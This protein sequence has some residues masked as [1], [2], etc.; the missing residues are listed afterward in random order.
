MKKLFGIKRGGLQKKMILIVLAM[1]AALVVVFTVV[2]NYQGSM[3]ERIVNDTGTEQQKAIS[4]TSGETLQKTLMETLVNT[5]AL[6]S[7]LADNDFSEVADNANMLATMAQV[8]LAGS[9]DPEPT[10]YG[11]PDPA[12]EGQPSA[13]VLCEE[14]VDY[15][16]SEYLAAISPLADVMLAMFKNS[17]KI[18]GCY[19]GLADGTDLC[20][21]ARPL[22]KLDENGEPI[23]FPV[24]E[25]PWYKGALEAGEV[26][27]T[28]IEEDAFSGKLMVTCSAPVI[29]NGETLGVVGIDIVMESMDD[30]M[31]LSAENGGSAF[32]VNEKGRVI[33]ST[34]TEGI[35]AVKSPSESRDLRQLGNKDLANFVDHA[36]K[37]NTA[38]K[39]ITI[40]GKQYY[41]SGSPMKTIGWTVISIIEKELTE[42][43]EKA[44][45]AEFDK[46]SKEAQ[47]AIR[48]GTANVNRSGWVVIAAIL[49]ISVWL[50]FYSVRKIT[51]P[52]NEMTENVI[53]SG[54]SGKQFELRDSYKTNDEIEILARA[55][56]DLSQKTRQYIQDIQEITKEKER[57]NTELTMASRI[58]SGSLP[59][60]FPAFPDRTEF[61]IYASMTPAKEVGGDFYDF[62][63]IDEDHLCMLIAD[64]SGK[65]IPGALFMMVS[66]A[67]LKN[68]AMAGI[69]LSEV[70][71]QT[72]ETICTN[73]KMEMFVTVWI[74]VLEISTGRLKAANAGH[75]Y[76][77][78]MKDGRFE[79]LKDKH[80]FVIGGMEGMVYKEYEMQ[81]EKGDKI[82]VYTDG[83]PEAADPENAMFGTDR[84]LDALNADPGASP[85]Q[86]MR[87]V[88]S[89][90]DIFVKGAERFDDLTMLCIEYKGP[91]EEKA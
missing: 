82:F 6:Q 14:G 42:Q 35:F 65:G 5:T 87:N 49:I 9:E 72:N 59:H 73:N 70:L 12:N 78:V 11:L 27:F 1:L 56:D 74:A 50:V 55:F 71:A 83:V 38:L 41:V 88:Q 86:L 76:P 81:L 39:D 15:T 85:Q 57:V 91:A 3:Y 79:L 68:N 26:Y 4:Q 67:I 18:D 66:K 30:F 54:K 80:G 90:V 84:M 32:V 61:D 45:I 58:Q 13:M 25:R 31:Q 29:V 60:E 24:R 22:N 51:G 33:V 10:K 21:D 36:L 34:E 23:P 52:L 37:T 44:M 75:E 48:T 7:N 64:V 89:E 28:G 53:E 16:G 46:I 20:I 19:I 43:P 17:D 63:F 62:F 47:A 2:S 69:P 40:E 8:M 77:A